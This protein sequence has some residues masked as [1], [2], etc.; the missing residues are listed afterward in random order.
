MKKIV[1]FLIG[2]SAPETWTLPQRSVLVENPETGFKQNIVYV[3]GA[4]TIWKQ[5]LEKKGD[6]LKNAKKEEIVFVHGTLSVSQDNKIL[7][8]Y[9]RAH[10]WFGVKF[11]IVDKAA[12]S[13]KLIE[14]ADLIAEAVTSLKGDTLDIKTV[15]LLV[16][17]DSALNEAVLE[18][19]AKVKIKAIQEP[20]S[21]IDAY[22]DKGEWKYK[23]V[24]AL[25]LS[26]EIL[27]INTTK[28][29]ILWTDS[30][31]P[32]LTLAVGQK[33][34]DELASFIADNKNESTLQSIS[35]KLEGKEPVKNPENANQE[36]LEELQKKYEEKFGA[37][38]PINMK[39]NAEWLEKKLLEEI[40]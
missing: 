5:E 26:K 29:A 23:K 36:K 27:T 11:N 7:I 10:P 8:E 3:P 19:E 12:D 28:T 34:I 21:I 39:N 9:L 35:L 16:F 37:I 17:G 6:I 15:A 1:F 2:N 30:K 40:K 18:L 4:D 20:Q 13:K 33:P 32:L 24:V 22:S 14:K 25:A 31:E 38:P